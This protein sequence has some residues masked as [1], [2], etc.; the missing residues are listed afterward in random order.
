MIV[1]IVAIPYYLFNMRAMIMVGSPLYLKADAW[2]ELV[3]Q[4]CKK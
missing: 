4:V 2:I 3:K 1:F